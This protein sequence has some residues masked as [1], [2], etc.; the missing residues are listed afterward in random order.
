[1]EGFSWSG[2][3]YASTLPREIWDYEAWARDEHR[4][5]FIEE[6]R[7]SQNEVLE[8]R[9][10]R[11][12]EERARGAGKVAFV[13][14]KGPTLGITPASAQSKAERVMAGV[15]RAGREEEVSP[16]GARGENGARRGGP[17]NQTQHRSRGERREGGRG[18]GG[19]DYYRTR[20]RDRERD[21]WKI[22]RSR[23]QS[24][25]RDREKERERGR[26]RR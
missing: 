6:L 23:S 25:S 7:K 22:N 2:E 26:F 20:D 11:A 3:Q 21:R 19:D 18:G 8:K 16:M 5:G 15:D 4:S 10:R 13:S 9:Q 12:E 24:R 1:M 17:R 14:E